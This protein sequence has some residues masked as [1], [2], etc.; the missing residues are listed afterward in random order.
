MMF[1]C[2]VCVASSWQNFPEYRDFIITN[3]FK[4]FI[5]VGRPGMKTWF[6]FVEELGG[7]EEAGTVAFVKSLEGLTIPVWD[8]GD[9]A[10][11]EAMMNQGGLTA[12]DLER[13][14]FPDLPKAGFAFLSG[15]GDIYFGSLNQV[16]RMVFDP[17]TAE[18]FARPW[19]FRAFGPGG[20]WFSTMGTTQTFLD[21]NPEAALRSVAAFYRAVRYL[22][23]KPEVVIPMVDEN[24]A[25]GTGGTLGTTTTGEIMTEL[26]YFPVA[27]DAKRD[28]F[29]AGSPLNNEDSISFLFER[30]VAA[31]EYSA[32]DDWQT[33][34]V[35][36]PWLDMLLARPDLM[37]YI[38]SPLP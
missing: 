21:A 32:D 31:G 2:Q 15:E 36:G 38:N 28:F 23:E 19:P 9:I 35:S 13:I 25:I 18:D 17:E 33:F 3:Q 16:A 29:T 11:T 20:L 22:H 1:S 4:G 5:L 26:N 27:E 24:V 30:G 7:D 34:Q 14:P 8:A 6:D 12:D 37:E 10:L